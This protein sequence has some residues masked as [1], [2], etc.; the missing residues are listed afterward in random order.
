MASGDRQQLSAC[1]LG[2]PYDWT[3][4][5][6]ASDVDSYVAQVPEERRAVLTEI[7]DACRRLLA[8]F[9]ESM[10]HGMPTYS[11]DGIA[12][13]AWASQKR[14]I[15]LYVMRTDVLD[16]HRSQLAGL[17]VGKGCI[18]Y[19]SPAAVDLTVVHSM[20]TAVAASRGPAC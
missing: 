5:S 13:V 4:H 6:D 10:S 16:A 11:R 3:V 7:R 20:L 18:R 1:P 2:R 12:E 19:R 9:A 15:S 8:G 17:D 14:Y